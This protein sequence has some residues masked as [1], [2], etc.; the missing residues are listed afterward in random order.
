MRYSDTAYFIAWYMTKLIREQADITDPAVIDMIE[1]LTNSKWAIMDGETGDIQIVGK[2]ENVKGLL[3]SNHTYVKCTYDLDVP[4][5]K[6]WGKY[7]VYTLD[8]PEDEKDS[9]WWDFP[10]IHD[11][12]KTDYR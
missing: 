7:P 9:P 8:E 1:V 4:K 12:S 10:W 5:G 11:Y 2:F 3:F 6:K